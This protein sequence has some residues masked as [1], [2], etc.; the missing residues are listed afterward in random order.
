MINNIVLTGRMVK[1]PELQN[2][3]AGVQLV[4]FTLAVQRNYSKEKKTDFINC[5]AWK[6]TAEF[7][8]KYGAKGRMLAVQG[9]LQIDAYTDKDG[10]NQK[11][12]KVVIREAEFIGTSEAAAAGEPEKPKE[13]AA[14]FCETVDYDLPF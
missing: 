8:T 5:E 14:G 7:I 11:A 10:K 12:A 4:R 13:A 6:H 2:T 3:P 1:D 9:N